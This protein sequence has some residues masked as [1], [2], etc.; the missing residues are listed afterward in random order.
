MSFICS[1]ASNAANV[2]PR[3]LSKP[4]RL[5]VFFRGYQ[6]KI[7]QTVVGSNTVNM[8]NMNIFWRVKN[9]AMFI[10]PYV[11]MS[12]FDLDVYKPAS[13]SSAFSSYWKF[14]TVLI[15]YC[16]AYAFDFFRKSLTCAV[17]AARR[18]MVGITVTTFTPVN[19]R[20]A[21]RTGF[22]QESFRHNPFYANNERKSNAF[23]FN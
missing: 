12:N 18:I 22:G 10:L 8:M 11:R 9:Y 13:R 6:N 15:Q 4:M 7:F 21:K 14:Y 5:S 3:P 2:F 17:R 19:G 16:A 20:T 1:T 23:C